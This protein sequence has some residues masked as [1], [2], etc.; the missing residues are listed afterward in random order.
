[1]NYLAIVSTRLLGSRI[2]LRAGREEKRQ[3]GENGVLFP[4]SV[5]I[6]NILDIVTKKEKTSRCQNAMRFSDFV[7]AGLQKVYL[8]YSEVIRRNF[9]KLRLEWDFNPRPLD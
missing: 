9:R 7:K 1:M 2:N 6:L 5:H 3:K 8:V 4:L